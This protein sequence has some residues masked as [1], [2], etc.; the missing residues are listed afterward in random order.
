MAPTITEWAPSSLIHHA[1]SARGVLEKRSFSPSPARSGSVGSF[2]AA[3][4]S[5]QIFDFLSSSFPGKADEPPIV[6]PHHDRG[7]PAWA[8]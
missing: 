5:F 8:P 4:M 6:V 7:H 1:V 3:A 2:S